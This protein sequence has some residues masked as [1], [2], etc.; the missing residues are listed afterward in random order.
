VRKS[1]NKAD[2]RMTMTAVASA[3]HSANKRRIPSSLNE[4][5]TFGMVLP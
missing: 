2:I 1:A 5:V 4:V 3:S